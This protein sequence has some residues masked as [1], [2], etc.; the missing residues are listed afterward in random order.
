MMKSEHKI[1]IFSSPPVLPMSSP[2]EQQIPELPAHVAIQKIFHIIK[3]KEGDVLMLAYDRVPVTWMD[4]FIRGI[5]QLL[6]YYLGEEMLNDIMSRDQICELIIRE[7]EK[8]GGF[9]LE[10]QRPITEPPIFEEKLV[11]IVGAE[12]DED[13]LKNLDNS[14]NDECEIITVEP[15]LTNDLVDKRIFMVVPERVCQKQKGGVV[16]EDLL[17]GL[18]L[19]IPDEKKT[20]I[21]GKN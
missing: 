13:W 17:T 10:R 2:R 9:K 8:T 16:I 1:I 21:S 18:R 4:Q 15:K 14:L 5:T 19:I 20:S 12:K 11:C 3:Q 6:A 7:T